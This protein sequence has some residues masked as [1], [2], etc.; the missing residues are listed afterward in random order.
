MKSQVKV[1]VI[2]NKLCPES[3]QEC[4]DYPNLDRC[5]CYHIGDEF[6][7]ERDGTVDQFEPKGLNSLVKTTADPDTVA[8]RPKEPHCS[9]V[10]DEALAR[11]IYAGLKYTE[12][13]GEIIGKSWRKNEEKITACCLH[14]ARSVIF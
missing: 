5:T 7:F 14:G 4:C 11:Y 6:I 2:D 9:V 12:L 8:G 3:G 1:T 13:R 10:W